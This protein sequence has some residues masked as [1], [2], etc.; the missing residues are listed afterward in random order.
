M[1]SHN[2]C[3][4]RPLPGYLVEDE[5]CQ[6]KDVYRRLYE[7]KQAINNGKRRNVRE[8]K[9]QQWRLRRDRKKREKDVKP[10]SSEQEENVITVY[11]PYHRGTHQII[12]CTSTNVQLCINESLI[13]SLVN[14]SLE[15]DTQH[16]EEVVPCAHRWLY[17]V[18]SEDEH[19]MV[20]QISTLDHTH[21]NIWDPARSLSFLK[22]AFPGQYPDDI[23]NPQGLEDDYPQLCHGRG[24]QVM[25]QNTD[26]T[27]ERAEESFQGAESGFPC[28]RERN[29]SSIDS[30]SH[31][32]RDSPSIDESSSLPSS[33]NDEGSASFYSHNSTTIASGDNI[34]SENTS[35]VHDESA[36][37]VVSKDE[38]DMS[39]S[40][41]IRNEIAHTIAREPEI[42]QEV[43]QEILTEP[44]VM[45][46]LSTMQKDAESIPESQREQ[47]DTWLGHAENLLIFAY[48]MYRAT[49]L[50][51][52][53]AATAAYVKMYIKGKSITH[54]LYK[55]V[56]EVTATKPEDIVPHGIMDEIVNGWDLLK[57]H[58]I[59]NKI[60]YLI[61]AALSLTVS[62]I[63]EIEWSPC[64]LKLIRIEA[65]KEQLKAVDLIDAV[66]R[67]FAWMTETGYQCMKE[68]SLA[69]LLYGNQRM[70]EFHILYDHVSA[71]ADSAMAGN[72][73][74]LG[75]FEQKTDQALALVTSLKKVKPDGTTA[76]WL[77]QKYEKLVEIK[78]KVIAKRRNTNT[79]FAPM[80]WSVSG[81][82][83]V[84][85]STLSKL[86]MNTSLRAMDFEANPSRIITLDDA[87]KYQSTYTSDIEGVY[88][89]DFA[90]MC[91]QF[92]GGNGDTPANRLIKFFN[93]MAAQAI[94]AEIQEKGVVFIEF[95]CGVI[96]TNVR[97][98]DAELYS[99][100][101]EAVLRRFYHI[102]VVV[103][104]K[105]R[106][107]GSVSLNA[108]HPEILAD[109]SIL[110][111]VWDL[112]IEEV[113]PYAIREGKIGY[114]FEPVVVE[115]DEGRVVCE[116]LSLSK[117]LKAVVALSRNHKVVQEKVVRK[118][119]EFDAI[120]YCPKCSLPK[121]LCYCDE[122]PEKVTC[123]EI[124][125]HAFEAL[126]DVVVDAA[127]QSL[128]SY[129]KSWISPVSWL[130]NLLGYS[131]I[132]RLATQQ[133]A[134]EL[135]ND[136]NSFA[137]PWM[138]AMVPDFLFSSKYFQGAVDYWQSSAAMYNY[139]DYLH[140]LAFGTVIG[141][142]ISA[143]KRSWRGG[144]ITSMIS[145]GGGCVLYA[146][147]CARK[148]QIRQ[149]YA[150]R[151]DALPT[152]V[153][154][155]RDG[156]V[157]KYALMSASLVIG[158]KLLHMWN[159]RRIETQDL[160]NPDAINRSKGWFENW[161][162][163]TGFK[164]ES[165]SAVKHVSVEQVTE[166]LPKN[167][168]WATFEREDGSRT[169]CNVVSFQNGFVLM[170]EHI[171]YTGGDMTKTPS[172][173]VNA[174][175]IKTSKGA[176][177]YFKFRAER[178]CHSYLFED[179]DMRLVYVP[180]LDNVKSAWKFL[181][182]THPTGSNVANFYIRRKD[183][184]LTV[185]TICATMKNVAHRYRAMKGGDYT[186][187][188]AI[189]GACMGMIT[190]KKKEPVILGFHIGGNGS[191]YGI[192]QT[193]TL[194]RYLEA[195]TTLGK[196][197]GVVVLAQ[198]TELPKQ[199][200]GRT[201]LAS[202]EVHD[203]AKYIKS[204]GPEAAISVFG[205]TKLRS[206]QV[207]CVEPSIL[208]KHVTEIMNVPCNFGPPK[209]E[210]NWDAYNATLEYIVNPSD[211]FLPSELERARQDWLKDL[212]PLMDAYAPK[213]GF[214]PMT[215]KE[216]IMGV[217]GKRF[218]DPLIMS[219]SM[220]F[221]VFGPK[222]KHFTE[223]REGERLVDRV[224][225]KGVLE[226]Y[227]RLLSHWK[228]GERAYPVCSATLKD[229]PTKIGKTKVRVFQAA[230][231]S[232]SLAIRMYFLPIAR[233]LSL[234]P[235]V[236]ESAVGINSFSPEWKELMDHATKFA[237][238]NKVI[239]WDYS[240]YDVRMNSQMT[241]A[242]LK[243]YIDLARRGGYKEEELSIMEA[244][245]ADIVHPM[246]DWNGTL[247]MAFNMNTSGN[248][249]TVNINST[250]GSFY[251]RMGFFHV[252][253][254][255]KDFRKCVAAMTY[256]DDFK[257]SV[258]SHYR[259]FDFFA[260]QS[261]LAQ[262]GMKITLPDKSDNSCAFME[263]EDADFLKRSSA[264]IEGIP[265]PIGRLAEESIFKSLHCNLRSKSTSKAEVA[266]SCMETALHEWFAYGRE[267]YEM[268]REQL[269]RVAY[270]AGLCPTKAF[271]PY[272]ERVATWHE[273]Y[274]KDLKL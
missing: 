233:F 145:T 143:Y 8:N 44:S 100:A 1:S 155:V 3:N 128:V 90:N 101:P 181:P 271:V 206:K 105:Y 238:D 89:D 247:I 185:E 250:A 203:K 42:P 175:V 28:D 75:A 157:P 83:G 178:A 161:L 144:L 10:H 170:P 106:K 263:E 40:I 211:Q 95:K 32:S 86:V 18:L 204:L 269:T 85:K 160:D 212:F 171:F 262:H 242:V 51:D 205:A 200:L 136:L 119:M 191:G 140:K 248:N 168:W 222:N 221:P 147:Y 231:V 183:G 80:G 152:Y 189:D 107:P 243:S 215:F 232:L 66:V 4:F 117:F 93:N 154:K 47:V 251:V 268:R 166:T 236:S 98:L 199:Q 240:K 139:R 57:H 22:Q 195:V 131:P 267:Y 252:Y 62:S 94:K 45:D 55:L 227:E 158:V 82:S 270:A 50:T 67:T 38:I 19:E 165:T 65:A 103:K 81:P 118:A 235:L 237:V 180:N 26:G 220:G 5:E 261:F 129:A 76:H 219:T 9:R 79:R 138:V 41:S 257:G 213:E 74:D 96:T 34:P 201:V 108:S 16:P 273:K 149:E 121:P 228:Q 258:N 27:L 226:E 182:L 69:P 230:P 151:R 29:Y 84:G 192:M 255:E 111:D 210:P 162:G 122:E 24:G 209:L 7:Q 110:K 68:R 53:F 112:T 202:T 13:Q 256:G 190:A 188:Q 120:E 194:P 25:W 135:Q 114:R 193:L 73:A 64:G 31:Y 126:G 142:G 54:E 249:I 37:N 113:I 23:T 92:A 156:C 87:D 134:N 164:Y 12:D 141:F 124:K 146:G 265:V 116:N 272:E 196:Q 163:S 259:K 216:S 104:P 63:K 241:T 197:D 133:L 217:D 150:Q 35:S 52:A 49:N 172:P 153:K 30:V 234:H 246:I 88:I 184:Q 254:D 223:I 78:E 15:Y 109:K 274:A 229:E 97:G 198:A 253:P 123:E 148:I 127:K 130:N 58:V 132:K 77:Q 48:Q 208:S 179:L 177:G 244:M 174:E 70:R 102:G 187:S 214:R 167:L 218:L 137:T 11:K 125:P 169:G 56:N 173:W 239:A 207:S 59:F 60:S 266:V 36:K 17:M 33:P 71:Y 43:R 99:N 61:S 186:S 225:S 176:G 264:T 2:D 72:Y 46:A 91:A 14:H 115:L 21:A 260:Y 39:P 20:V 224:P 245:I 6:P 159:T